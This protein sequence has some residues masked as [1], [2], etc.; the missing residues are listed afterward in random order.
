[1]LANVYLSIVT[2]TVS[3]FVLKMKGKRECESEKA[4]TLLLNQ[5]LM[6][7]FRSLSSRHRIQTFKEDSAK[8]AQH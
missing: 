6:N 2:S 7:L 8:D 3:G 4:L 5:L 1:M